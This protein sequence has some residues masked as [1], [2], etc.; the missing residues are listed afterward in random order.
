MA[1]LWLVGGI[2]LLLATILPHPPT[3]NIPLLVIIGLT[4]CVTAAA[5]HRM[6]DRLPIASHPWLMT[7][8]TGIIT[9]LVATGGSTSMSVAF[10]F[11]YIWVVLYSL[12]F[13]SRLATVIQLG[14]A[15]TAYATVL[16]WQTT[17]GTE[18]FTA[19]EPLVLAAVAS[20]TGIIVNMLMHAR[21]TSEI[22]PLTE[23]ANRRG[24]DRHLDLAIDDARATQ[25][26]LVIAMIDV[27]HFKSFNEQA[28][29]AGGD[30]I[31][32]DLTTA[33]RPVLRAHD[34]IG[35]FGGDEFVVVLPA[36]TRHAAAAILERLRAAAPNGVTCSIGAAQWHTGESASMCLS[37]ADSALYDA[38]RAGRDRVAWGPERPLTRA[39]TVPT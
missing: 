39:T 11:F 36:C 13:L 1:L 4:S 26:D 6:A 34:S 12:M 37:K 22:D 2:T 24:L 8:G 7:V 16:V 31:L 28:G 35:R 27:D 18:N 30:Q 15:G 14:L 3:L 5:I 19:V 29:H 23:T 17:A 10:S 25:H 32:K 33:W 20:T 9:T 38:K 21:D